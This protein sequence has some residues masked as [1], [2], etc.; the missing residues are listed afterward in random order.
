MT[1]TEHAAYLDGHDDRE[2]R[3]HGT[4]SGLDRLALELRADVDP[5]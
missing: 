1:Y 2:Q 3:I 5:E 4:E